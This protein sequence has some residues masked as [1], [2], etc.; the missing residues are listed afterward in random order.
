MGAYVF[1]FLLE[2]SMKEFLVDHHPNLS[3][4]ISSDPFL[5]W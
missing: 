2:I 3:V 4:H 1:V 5:R